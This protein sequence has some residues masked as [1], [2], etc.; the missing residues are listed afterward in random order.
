MAPKLCYETVMAILTSDEF[1]RNPAEAGRVSREE[2]VIITEAWEQVLVLLSIEAYR[3]LSPVKTSLLDT[4]AMD[5]DIR[6]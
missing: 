1:E 5:E 4:L 3:R 2:T 6:V